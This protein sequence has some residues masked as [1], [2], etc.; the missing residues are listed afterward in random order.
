MLFFGDL[1]GHRV[2][3]EIL[4]EDAGIKNSGLMDISLG[5]CGDKVTADEIQKYVRYQTKEK[6]GIHL[7][8]SQKEQLSSETQS[9]EV[10]PFC[11][12]GGCHYV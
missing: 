5:L 3:T 4:P 11:G 8:S 1:D 6:Q 2:L 10:P 9:R 7:S 12:W